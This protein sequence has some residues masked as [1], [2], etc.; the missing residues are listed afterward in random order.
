MTSLSLYQKVSDDKKLETSLS[1]GHALIHKK[2]VST[3]MAAQV[4]ALLPPIEPALVPVVQKLP[5]IMSPDKPNVTAKD[6][7]IVALPNSESEDNKP[8]TPTLEIS[9]TDIVKILEKCESN[10][11]AL[12]QQVNSGQSLY[13]SKQLVQQKNSPKIPIFTNCTISGNVTININKN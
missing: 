13:V 8:R 9:D 10:S 1:L 5:A 4:K 11:M 3:P 7:L 12:T 2:V 6:N